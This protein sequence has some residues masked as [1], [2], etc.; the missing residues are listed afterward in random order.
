MC[1]GA[2]RITFS[3]ELT[4]KTYRTLITLIVPN[5]EFDA[6]NANE[7]TGEQTTHSRRLR[8]VQKVRKLLKAA[9]PL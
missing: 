1:S 9:L 3:L 7:A 8:G 6:V 5:P 4:K 2:R